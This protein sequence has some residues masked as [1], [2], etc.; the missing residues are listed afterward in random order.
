MKD[1]FYRDSA[2]MKRVSKTNFMSLAGFS[3]KHSSVLLLLET[4]R[5]HKNDFSSSTKRKNDIW[6]RIA[7]EMEETGYTVK[8]LQCEKKWSNLKI[9]YEKY[10]RLPF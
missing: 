7:Q 10:T 3:W 6:K 2:Q 9:R 1:K 8:P 5:A 4:Y